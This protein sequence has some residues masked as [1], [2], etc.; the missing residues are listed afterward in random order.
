MAVRLLAGR[1]EHLRYLRNAPVGMPFLTFQLKV[2]PRMLEVARTAPWR[3][4]APMA[5]PHK[6]TP[7]GRRH[8]RRDDDD[9]KAPQKALPGV[10]AE[11]RPCLRC[12]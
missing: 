5:L 1:A 12:P 8:G 2:L 3:F 7:S 9:V 10:V 4:P 11:S 6:L